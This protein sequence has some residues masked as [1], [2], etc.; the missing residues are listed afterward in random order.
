MPFKSPFQEWLGSWEV[1]SYT[2][3]LWLQGP[4]HF[5]RSCLP[6]DAKALYVFSL[7]IMIVDGNMQ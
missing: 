5:R 3:L 4:S 2:V 1:A 6:G 7:G